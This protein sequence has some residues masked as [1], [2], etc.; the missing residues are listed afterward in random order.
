MAQPMGAI[1]QND[2]CDHTQISDRVQPPANTNIQQAH[3]HPAGRNV[4]FQQIVGILSLSITRPL[5][6]LCI[7]S[8][9]TSGI[10]R[11]KPR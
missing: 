7:D 4:L 10:E 6:L 9:C 11:T 3:G 1:I 8:L 2:Y 5:A